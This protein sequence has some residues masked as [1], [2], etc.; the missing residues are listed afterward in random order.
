MRAG[1]LNQRCSV[2]RPVRTTD[3]LGGVSV[4][5]VKVAETWCS[6]WPSSGRESTGAGGKEAVIS[7]EVRMRKK[8]VQ[9]LAPDYRID[10][11]TRA[12]DVVS[13]LNVEERGDQWR[14]LAVEHL[15]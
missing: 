3:S 2:K 5:W 7:H 15:R 10:I 12:F 4:S 13:V 6:V 9:E 1:T 14:V 11:G 8:A